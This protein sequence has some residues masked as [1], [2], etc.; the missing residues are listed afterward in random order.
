MHVRAPPGQRVNA[1][2][3]YLGLLLISTLSFPN[4]E[5]SVVAHILRILRAYLVVFSEYLEHTTLAVCRSPT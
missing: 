1:L 4:A 3:T 2:V 5:L